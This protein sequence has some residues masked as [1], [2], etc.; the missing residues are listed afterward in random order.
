MVEVT[1]TSV[2]CLV[3][4]KPVSSLR[5]VEPFYASSALCS[6]VDWQAARRSAASAA[7]RA[8]DAKG[9]GAACLTRTP[10]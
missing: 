3:T 4:F 6:W 2:L 10:R 8:A 7:A 9:R 1:L 5:T